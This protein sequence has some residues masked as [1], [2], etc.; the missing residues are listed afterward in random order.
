MLPWHYYLDVYNARWVK[1]CKLTSLFEHLNKSNS[2]LCTGLKQ[3]NLRV[4]STLQH[5]HR[6]NLI[7]WN[8][9]L[10]TVL[11]E[12]LVYKIILRINKH[13]WKPNLKYL[14]NFVAVAAESFL[15]SAFNTL[16]DNCNTSDLT[17][18]T[19][20]NQW[21]LRVA[22]TLHHRQRS[23]LIVWNCQLKTMKT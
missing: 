2:T 16:M 9:Q 6:S 10:K 5:R 7:V 11:V 18:C 12:N 13:T 3:W 21:N 15:S 23:I 14:G 8:C 22:S 19:V 20:M 4:A 1:T 17:L